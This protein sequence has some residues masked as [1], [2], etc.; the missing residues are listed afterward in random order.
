MVKTKSVTEST[1]VTPM[2]GRAV[3][4]IQDAATGSWSVAV[5]EFSTE[6]GGG[7]VV[8][9]TPVGPSKMEASEKFKRLAVEE[10]IVV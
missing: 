7:R 1:I 3:G 5:L 8:S 2:T 9:T 6:T 10:G 4:I